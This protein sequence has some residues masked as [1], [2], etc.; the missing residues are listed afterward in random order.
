[1]GRRKKTDKDGKARSP[2]Q[3]DQGAAAPFARPLPDDDA[4]LW[5]RVTQS[6]T[7]LKG[8]KD[9]LHFGPLRDEKPVL[10][11]GDRSA[12]AGVPRQLAQPQDLEDLR[13]A[14]ER[15]LSQNDRPQGG[16]G[17]AS[18][19]PGQAATGKVELPAAA[20]FSRREMRQINN[21]RQPIEARLDLH[22]LYQEAAHM[23]L[24]NFLQRCHQQDLRHVLVITGKGRTAAPT[25][26]IYGEAEHGVLRRVVPLWLGEPDLL[27]LVAGFS[28]APRR[29]GGAG[30]L[31][32]RLRRNRA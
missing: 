27:G 12:G 23:A 6:L 1:M 24:R 17:A 28:Q 29:H 7:P 32:V 21:G 31:Y 19:A 5:A 22:G 16:A 11:V 13:A 3:T 30:A 26:L 9:R 25:E 8:E 18:R 14:F 2:D 10:S 20:D 4:A 15:G